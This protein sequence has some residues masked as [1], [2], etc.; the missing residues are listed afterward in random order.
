MSLFFLSSKESCFV[1]FLSSCTGLLLAGGHDSI[2]QVVYISDILPRS[3]AAREESL[4]ALDIIHYING[5]STQGMTLKEA[6]RTLETS[7]PWVVLKVTRCVLELHIS[8]Y[9]LLFSL[10]YTWVKHASGITAIHQ[11]SISW[12][13]IE[14][15]CHKKGTYTLRFALQCN[16]RALSTCCIL[17]FLGRQS[18]VKQSSVQNICKI[19]HRLF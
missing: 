7:L 6:K 19:W 15:W 4:H 2:Y 12:H 8:L 16:R 1:F 17:C 5:V 10:D 13:I 18:C 9:L 14:D 3:A 11:S